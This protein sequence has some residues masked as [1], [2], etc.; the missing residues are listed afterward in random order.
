M[1]WRFVSQSGEEAHR[2]VF[3]WDGATAKHYTLSQALSSR[4]RPRDASVL[5]ANVY[6]EDQQRF[7]G[8][9][10][11]SLADLTKKKTVESWVK[12]HGVNS[13]AGTLVLSDYI[14]PPAPRNF[15]SDWVTKYALRGGGFPVLKSI[16][17]HDRSWDSLQM[18]RRETRR[19]RMPL[20]L[21]GP[22]FAVP[23]WMFTTY[24]PVS[25]TPLS[26]SRKAADI[27]MQ[28]T[29]ATL[30]DLEHMTDLGLATLAWYHAVYCHCIPYSLEEHPMRRGKPSE[31]FSTPSL[32]DTG[33]CEDV[34]WAVGNS[35]R[36]LRALLVPDS[37]SNRAVRFLQAMNKHYHPWMVLGAATDA[38]PDQK[39]QKGKVMAHMYVLMIPYN[40]LAFAGLKLPQYAPAVPPK[41]SSLPILLV[42]GTGTVWPIQ[43]ASSFPPFMRGA[44]K[45]LSDDV[46]RKSDGPPP[47]RR[48]IHSPGTKDNE[49]RVAEFYLDVVSGVSAYPDVGMYAFLR[50]DGKVGPLLSDLIVD[51]QPNFKLTHIEGTNQADPNYQKEHA[52]VSRLLRLHEPTMP[53]YLSTSPIESGFFV[54]NLQSLTSVSIGVYHGSSVTLG[55]SS[56]YDNRTRFFFSSQDVGGPRQKAFISMLSTLL[57]DKKSQIN[58]SKHS[59]S[60]VGSYMIDV[61]FE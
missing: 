48:V 34:S 38:S 6:I 19:F 60:G 50:P 1:S 32:R 20:W 39:L 47:V 21:F 43:K 29:D 59:F 15:Y 2:V 9:A 46:V 61:Y 28:R 17:A 25:T 8:T 10:V 36:E 18:A 58:I 49:H 37:P 40:V 56:N 11:Y 51:D 12:R 41:R 4:T 53:R 7:L 30:S 5:L 26:V 55:S 57:G 33:D 31:Y 52:N 35:C 3:F 27:A 44:G 22:N 45:Q 24:T 16:K 42:E 13:S 23:G 14:P 54:E